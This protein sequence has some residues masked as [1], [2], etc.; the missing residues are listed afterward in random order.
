MGLLKK[1]RNC[2]TIL[3][4]GIVRLIFRMYV[5]GPDGSSACTGD[6][7]GPLSEYLDGTVYLLGIVS[8]GPHNCNDDPHPNVYTDIRSYQDWVKAK[9]SDA[10]EGI[11]EVFEADSLE[12]WVPDC[13]ASRCFRSS[14]SLCSFVESP[15]VRCKNKVI[16][17]TRW[18]LRYA[19]RF[20]GEKFPKKCFPNSKKKSKIF[21]AYT[22]TD[23][24]EGQFSSFNFLIF[25]F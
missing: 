4:L 14:G 7:G 12:A 2:G 8:W 19:P 24:I 16:S 6:S 11:K 25:Q 1:I 9:T 10:T 23:V 13:G 17:C 3:R 18:L 15:F 21:Y 20:H 5:T 22:L